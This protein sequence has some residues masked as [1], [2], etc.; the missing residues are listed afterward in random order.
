MMIRVENLSFSYDK[1]SY[2]LK[3][4]NLKLDTRPTAVIGQNGA[5]KTTFVK[6]LKG[7]LKPTE[8]TIY[9]RDK[10]TANASAASLASVIGLVFQNPNDQIF[11]KTVLEEVLYGP[12]NIKMEAGLAEKNA[13]S[14]LEFLGL[15]KKIHENPHD[16]SLSEKKLV[17]IAAIA[18]MDTDIIILDEPVIG[19]DEEGRNKIKALISKWKKKGKLVMTI[20]HDM[21]FAAENFERIL[22]F[23]E[24][25]LLLDG[26]GKTVFGR[27]DILR[28][29]HLEA[30]G[31]TQLGQRLELTDTCLTEGEFIELICN[32]RKG[33]E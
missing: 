28:K 14:A 21:D 29:A 13:L 1:T 30:P 11:K 4:L 6:L 16:L 32:K 2:V 19:Q 9:I 26:E 18:A 5:G 20:I 12:L 7:L 17:C 33:S 10:N 15:S 23:N 8:G 22:V 25:E 3:S 31:I 27:A 24:G